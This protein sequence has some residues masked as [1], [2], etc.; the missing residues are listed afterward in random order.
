MAKRKRNARRASAP[1]KP[2]ETKRPLGVSII[3]ILGFVGALVLIAI[4]I[5]LLVFAELGEALLMSMFPF[6]GVILKIAIGVVG[7][8]MILLGVLTLVIS[9]GLWK[10]KKWA[11]IIGMVLL[12]IGVLRDL[13]SLVVSPLSSTVGIAVNA[14]ILYYLWTNRELF[15]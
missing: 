5:A 3:S 14:I 4:G 10:M 2:K 11:W 13:G 8:I 15:K 12:G 6:F 1:R 9:Y 7:G